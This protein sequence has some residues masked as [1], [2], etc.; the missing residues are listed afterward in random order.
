MMYD[1]HSM[2]AEE[3]ICHEEVLAS[4]KYADDN[5][6]NIQL[7]DEILNKAMGEERD[8]TTERLLCF[9]HVMCRKRLRKCMTLPNRLKRIFTVTE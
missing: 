6:D 9:L 2:K 8:L 3:F 5:K 1:V 4:L 7:I